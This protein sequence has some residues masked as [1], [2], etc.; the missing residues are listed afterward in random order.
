M[1]LSSTETEKLA[2]RVDLEGE[3]EGYTVRYVEF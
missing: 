3:Y 2:G 1:K